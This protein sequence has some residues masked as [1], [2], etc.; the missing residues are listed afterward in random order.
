MAMPGLRSFHP[1]VSLD[2]QCRLERAGEGVMCRFWI[3]G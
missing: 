3:A 2:G 1:E